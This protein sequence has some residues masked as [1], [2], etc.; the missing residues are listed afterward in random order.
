VVELAGAERSACAASAR[1]RHGDA[2]GARAAERS[3]K[4]LAPAHH[5]RLCPCRR[6]NNRD[7]PTPQLNA[8]GSPSICFGS[9]GHAGLAVWPSLANNNNSKA[10]WSAWDQ[11]YNDSQ[12]TPPE[13][14]HVWACR[15]AD[16]QRQLLLTWC[17]YNNIAILQKRLLVGLPKG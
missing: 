16:L 9:C 6:K 4:Q 15:S 5:H 12:L 7:S 1:V 13:I 10:P 14:S 2:T 3:P 8:V 17:N 11:L